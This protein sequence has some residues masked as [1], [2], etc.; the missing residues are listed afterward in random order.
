LVP[1]KPLYGLII[2]IMV[3]VLVPRSR[4]VAEMKPYAWADVDGYAG[5]TVPWAIASVVVLNVTTVVWTI[6]YVVLRHAASPVVVH[7][8]S[9]A[10]RSFGD[11]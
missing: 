6:T 5:T 9:A 10:M 1:L 8:A 2:I 7:A 11:S 4:V 3:P